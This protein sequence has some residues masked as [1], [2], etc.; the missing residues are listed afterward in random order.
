[1]TSSSALPGGRRIDVHVSGLTLGIERT[2]EGF[3]ATFYSAGRA[4]SALMLWGDTLRFQDGA[5]PA[6]WVGDQ[7]CIDIDP[8]MFQVVREWHDALPPRRTVTRLAG[9][10]EAKPIDNAEAIATAAAAQHGALCDGRC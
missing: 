10:P 6:I 2:P 3:S 7:A 4:V 8:Q 5:F 1:M 9:R